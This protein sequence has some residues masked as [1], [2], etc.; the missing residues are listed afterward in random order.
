[1]QL[2]TQ[3]FTAEE[4]RELEERLKVALMQAGTRVVRIKCESRRKYP[5]AHAPTVLYCEVI[6]LPEEEESR[7]LEQVL[8]FS[9]YERAEEPGVIWYDVDVKILVKNAD[10]A[11]RMLADIMDGDATT[12]YNRFMEYVQEVQEPYTTP[13]HEAKI[14]EAGGDYVNRKVEIRYW[15]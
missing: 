3:S 8:K 12:I 9:A 11:A 14:Y 13:G 4:P 2:R 7:E 10:K 6:P 15:G 1:M 5:S